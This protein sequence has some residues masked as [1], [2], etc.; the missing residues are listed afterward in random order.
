[1][2]MPLDYQ[3]DIQTKLKSV[4]KKI[5]GQ[6]AERRM[7]LPIESV[8]SHHSS[9]KRHTP[10]RTTEEYQPEAGSFF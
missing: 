3:C 6:S 8:C 4:P 7:N 9:R 10:K 2:A 1:M 5:K